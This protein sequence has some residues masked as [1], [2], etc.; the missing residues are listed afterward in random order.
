MN[1]QPTGEVMPLTRESIEKHLEIPAPEA[2]EE[3]AEA[4]PAEEAAL[5]RAQRKVGRLLLGFAS[6]CASPT[7]RSAAT[8]TDASSAMSSWRTGRTSTS[9][10]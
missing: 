8:S 3:T 1:T 4:P 10:S 9:S 5:D 2:G 7:E 6:R